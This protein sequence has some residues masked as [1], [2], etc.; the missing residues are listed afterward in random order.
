MV[1]D[2]DELQAMAN[3]ANSPAEDAAPAAQPTEAPPAPAAPTAGSPDIARILRIHVPVIV[4][5]ASRRMPVGTLRQLSP[6]VIVELGKPVDEPLELLI[7]NHAAARGTAVKV[8]ERFGLR[9]TQIRDAATRIKSM[10]K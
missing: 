9:I 8:G 5:L 7:N 1:V 10:G 4:R 3:E 6:G 2:Q